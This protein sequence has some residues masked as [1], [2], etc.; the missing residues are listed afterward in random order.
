MDTLHQAYNALLEHPI[1]NGLLPH[2]FTVAGFLL[3][4]LA[5]A[6]LMSERRQPGNTFAWLLA[7]G[8]IPYLGVPLYLLFGG[9]KIKR[10]VARK[11][12]LLFP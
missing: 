6:R 2:L 12:R 8:F 11:T 1:V 5:L 4:F 9:R 7:I 3:A 10:L